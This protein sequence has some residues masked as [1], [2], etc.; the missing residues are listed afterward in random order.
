MIIG[1][2]V[3]L[4][5]QKGGILVDLNPNIPNLNCI[6]SNKLYPNP[7]PRHIRC[8]SL[9]EYINHSTPPL[10][11]RTSTSVDHTTTPLQ[12][13]TST[14]ID[15]VTTPLQRRTSTPIDRVTTPLQRHVSTSVDRV[16]TPL[17]HR[18][19]TSGSL[20]SNDYIHISNNIF[21]KPT[22]KKNHTRHLSIDT[23]LY[24]DYIPNS[25]SFYNRN[26][27][28][29]NLSRTKTVSS[30]SLELTNDRNTIARDVPMD[31]DNDN[32]TGVI[33]TDNALLCLKTLF[34]PLSIF[35]HVGRMALTSI[36]STL[37]FVTAF[38]ISDLLFFSFLDN[39]YL[40]YLRHVFLAITGIVALFS[41]KGVFA[42]AI[43]LILSIAKGTYSWYCSL[44]NPECSFIDF[45]LGINEMTMEDS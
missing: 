36:S 28:L 20:D 19:S 40:S 11:R 44:I 26:I 43:S 24:N 42:S 30:P 16:T 23:S 21:V 31:I 37:S 6:P 8:A 14:S 9:P 12:R 27:S 10:Q 22:H 1:T 2:L 33:L 34:S 35:F 32:D 13:R 17:Q 7:M 15:R 25:N 38:A 4:S 45:V 41:I 39:F 18:T 5:T 29:D 3:L